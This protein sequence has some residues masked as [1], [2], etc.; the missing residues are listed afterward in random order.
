MKHGTIGDGRKFGL[1]ATMVTAFIW[2]WPTIFIKLLSYDFDIFTQSFYRYLASASFLGII[3][4]V[5]MRKD[6]TKAARRMKALVLPAILVSLFQMTNVAGVYL[7]NATMTGLISRTSV[8]FIALF[9]Y[10]LYEAE[11]RV[12]RSRYFLLANSLIVAGVLGLVLGQPKVELEFNLG[13]LITIGAAFFWAAYIISI[14]R[15]VDEFSP[16]AAMPIVHLMGAGIFL[17]TA[18]VFGDITRVTAVGWEVNLLLAGSG[19]L[20][21][22]L[23]NVANYLA[24]R[25][26]GTTLPANIM[27]FKPLL[28]MFFAY[29]ILDEVLTIPQLLSGILF[30]AGTWL[31]I[32]KVSVRYQE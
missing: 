24:I 15:I 13:V 23:G 11:R 28:T 5:F 29:L 30:L 2:A 1:A 3:A 32:R 20:C 19:V 22:G 17:P 27:T 21:V 12:M 25:H 7:T 6:L 18:I 8:A 26:L 14:R 9:S 4:I 10:V 31:M 16:I